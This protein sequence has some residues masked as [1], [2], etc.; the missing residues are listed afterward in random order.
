MSSLTPI[1]LIVWT[2][3]LQETLSYAFEKSNLKNTVG[4]LND[5]A[6]YKAS[7]IKKILFKMNLR[8]KNAVC[9]GLMMFLSMGW[10]PN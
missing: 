10:S 7:W 3:N 5:L 6:Q 2:K 8:D 9:S 4:C 1:L